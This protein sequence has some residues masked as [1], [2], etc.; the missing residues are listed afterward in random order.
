MPSP[1]S[2]VK[3]NSCF[4]CSAGEPLQVQLGPEADD[5]TAL[6]KVN[7]AAV[8]Q[9]AVDAMFEADGLNGVRSFLERCF[10]G[11]CWGSEADGRVSLGSEASS[12][13]QGVGRRL[14]VL[15]SVLHHRA[16]RVTMLNLPKVYSLAEHVQPGRSAE[17]QE[18]KLV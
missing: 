8:D 17:A 9:P 13:H 2:R 10:K 1:G 16:R 3:K 5:F 15:G 12:C 14:C 11:G 7:E 18:Y 6:F 4:A